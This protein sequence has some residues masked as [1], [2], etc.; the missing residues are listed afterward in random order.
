M[1][2]HADTEEDR[3]TEITPP[4]RPAAPWRVTHMEVLPGFRLRV[5]FND[6][7]EGI[8]ELADFLNSASAGVFAA[9]RDEGLFRRAQVRLG[10]VT[11]PDNLDLAP[12]AMHREIKDHGRWIVR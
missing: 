12:D 11:W 10:V 7:T 6:G 5:R 1:R 2:S 9:L 8:V 4:V 3:S